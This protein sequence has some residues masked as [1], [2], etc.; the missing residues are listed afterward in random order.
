MLLP[1]F[2][3]G[4]KN[5]IFGN[6]IV[7]L[8][9]PDSKPARRLISEAKNNDKYIDGTKGNAGKCLILLDTK[10]IVMSK[11]EVKTIKNRYLKYAN[12]IN[13][14]NQKLMLEPFLELGF[15]NYVLP[16]NVNSILNYN[17]IP[18]KKIVKNSKLTN[19]LIDCTQGRKTRS[20]ITLSNGNIVISSIDSKTIEKRYMKYVDSI[21][22]INLDVENIIENIED[23]I[24]LELEEDNLD[25]EEIIV[26]GEN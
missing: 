23:E 9:N 12:E 11:I 7:I 13:S 1:M 21:Y 20:V 10:E 17:S 8:L 3:V 24:N 4:F 2:S 22:K 5:Y 15:D 6:S 16:Y 19:T 14:K 26:L 18:I 25:N